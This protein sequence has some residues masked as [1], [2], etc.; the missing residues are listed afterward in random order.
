[1][2]DALS[3]WRGK[4]VIVTYAIAPQA[5]V[6]GKM[7]DVDGSGIVVDFADGRTF[8]PYVALLRVIGPRDG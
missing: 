5:P 4:P 3:R 1:M 2:A 8:I 6:Q 7:H